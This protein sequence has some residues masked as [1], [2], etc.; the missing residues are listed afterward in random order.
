MEKNNN[1]D[2]EKVLDESEGS[3]VSRNE[4]IPTNQEHSQEVSPEQLEKIRNNI[5]TRIELT[6]K[7]WIAAELAYIEARSSQDSA[8]PEDEESRKILEPIFEDMLEKSREARKRFWTKFRIASSALLVAFATPDRDSKIPSHPGN[9]TFS[10]R[11]EAQ[12][13]LSKNGITDYQRQAYFGQ[14]SDSLERG[15]TPIGYSSSD[16][17][18]SADVMR[19]AFGA[20]EGVFNDSNDTLF[21]DERLAKLYTPQTL[22][23][24]R[25]EYRNRMDAWR[26]YLG[27][28]QENQ[29]FGI[30]EYKPTKSKEDRYYYS[31]HNFLEDVSGK[32]HST[33]GLE[34]ENPMRALVVLA[35]MDLANEGGTAEEISLRNAVRD[36]TN[37][38]ALYDSLAGIMGKFTLKQ[39]HDEQGDYISY[40]D[41]WDLDGSVEG[42]DGM[43]GKPFEI[44]D[45]I[46]YNPTTYE[47]VHPKVPIS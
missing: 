8:E 39:G 20:M 43:I 34:H 30:S 31:I 5:T 36:K 24:L 4:P 45:R 15:F 25:K 9:G 23:Y 44:Y 16:G 17:S 42:K 33:H 41:R 2:W 32:M 14:L 6:G 21:K 29:T 27:I 7:K 13:Q 18:V 19:G 38:T 1:V 22:E 3:P 40:Y 11:S 28:P 10:E 26:L 35:G 46:Y 37:H 12:E 47:V